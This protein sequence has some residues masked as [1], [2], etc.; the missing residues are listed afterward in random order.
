[1][2]KHVAEI[3]EDYYSSGLTISQI[4]EKYGVCARTV[5]NSIQAK[6]RRNHARPNRRALHLT[7]AEAEAILLCIMEAESVLS[8]GYRET[9]HAIENRVLIIADELT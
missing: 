5:Y 4:A 9:L 6:N 8:D 7:K 1:M 2:R 3:S